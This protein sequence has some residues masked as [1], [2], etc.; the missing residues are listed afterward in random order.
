MEYHEKKTQNPKNVMIVGGGVAGMEAARDAILKGHTVTLYERSDH[1]GGELLAAGNRP[2]KGEVSELND[3][4]QREL[5]ELNAQIH[6]NVEMTPE[7]I[8]A[9]KPD[10]VLLTVG[11]SSVMP[12]SIP[13][14]RH[15]KS[16]SA[17]DALDGSR[18]V[19]DTVVVVG[20]GEIGCE[21][22]MHFAI[23]GKNVSLVEAMPDVMSVEFVPNQC[24]SM[25]KDMMEYYHVSI[26]T[27]S[28]LV[29]VNDEG[30]VI[31]ADGE[32]K[33]LKAD[34]VVLSIGMR[35]NP[36][37]KEA[38][39]GNGIEVYEIGS[40]K[41]PGNIYKAVHDAFEVVYNLD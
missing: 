30:A 7:S 37:M 38:L 16:I 32:T 29:E 31:E 36:S 21:A 34:S 18:T 3:W 5:K 9:Q 27:G 19:G 10:I 25:L 40:G 17:L 22:A 39:T 41:Q 26:Y 13:G 12:G 1:L 35:R 15:E 28:R 20:G 33:L 4:Y 24:K 14:I 6:L 11:A 2:L 23:E 8:I